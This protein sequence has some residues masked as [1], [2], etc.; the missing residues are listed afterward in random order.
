MIDSDKFELK[1]TTLDFSEQR[2][3]DNGLLWKSWWTIRPPVRQIWTPTL[4]DSSPVSASNES[5]VW[6]N[7][8]ESVPKAK[9]S[10]DVIQSET[11]ELLLCTAMCRYTEPLCQLDFCPDPDVMPGY[12]R[13]TSGHTLS[14]MCSNTTPAEFYFGRFIFECNQ[15]DISWLWGLLE[16]LFLRLKNHKRNVGRVGRVGSWVSGEIGWCR[17]HS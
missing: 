14:S 13:N 15:L 16:R 10:S 2:S 6:L 11:F 17:M 1:N 3:L 9:S 4:T 8:V 12:V 5:N 7:D